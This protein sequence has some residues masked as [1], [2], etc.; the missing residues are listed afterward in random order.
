ME[1]GE[2]FYFLPYCWATVAW[3]APPLK[4]LLLL[5][6]FSRAALLCVVPGTV[7]LPDPFRGGGGS[8]GAWW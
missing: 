1:E 5:E 8:G 3:D 2:L 4:L 7:L 6:N